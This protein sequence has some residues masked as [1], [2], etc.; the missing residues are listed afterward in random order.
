MMAR[1]K[2]TSGNNTITFDRDE[3]ID[4]VRQFLEENDAC[5]GDWLN[6]FQEKFLGRTT[7]KVRVYAKL[8]GYCE[9]EV[10]SDHSQ[11]TIADITSAIAN[12]KVADAFDGWLID[13]DGNYTIEN[14]EEI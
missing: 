11:P 10:T 13:D 5:D 4:A 7:K 14:T 6:K 3:L 9:L 2:K 1:K 12:M 8:R